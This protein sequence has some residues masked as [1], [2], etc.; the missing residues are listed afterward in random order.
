MATCPHCPTHEHPATSSAPATLFTPSFVTLLGLQLAF[1]FSFS[2]FYLLPKFLAI[3]LRARPA[4]IG[5]VM[6]M[7]GFASVVSMPLLAAFIDRVE[8]RVFIR[9]G[10][11]LMAIAAFGYLFVHQVGPLAASLRLIQGL[12]WA[13]TFTASVALTSDTTPPQRMTEGLG[14]LGAANL[15]MNALAPAV[16]ELLAERAGY[17][18]T[19]VLAGVAAMV[20]TSLS[21]RLRGSP[22]AFRSDSS[23]LAAFLRGRVARMTAP[24]MATVGIAFG[25]MFTFYQPAAL[26]QGI[27]RV[28]DFFLAY[29]AGALVVRLG[30]ARIADRWGR[31]LVTVAALI[32]Y[33]AS[34]IAMHRVSAFGLIVYGGLFGVAHGFFYPAFTAMVLETA[35]NDERG[36]L[37]ALTNG[38][39]SVGTSSVLALGFAVEH[40]GYGPIFVL[41]GLGTLASATLLMAWPAI[42]AKGA[43]DR[44]GAR[45]PQGVRR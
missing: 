18:A 5:G 8:R 9:A 30:V 6:G 36:K 40:L 26:E 19:F 37:V 41:A 17:R 25:V 38:F 4:A 45:E 10:S 20:A 28:R 21:L 2:T 29:T 22:I 12:A 42:V 27:H 34:V 15:A 33:G 14:V 13:L 7:F 24:I 35:R 11:A 44:G 39:F 23:S 31:H 3:E 32:L 16:A 43:E 1:A